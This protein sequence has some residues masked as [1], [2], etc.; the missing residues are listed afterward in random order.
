MDIPLALI[1]D[2]AAPD[3][4]GKLNIIGAFNRIAPAVFPYTHPMMYLVIK[5]QP[6]RGEYDE[7]RTA[8]AELVDE[9]GHPLFRIEARFQVPR[10]PDHS[11]T[12]LNIILNMVG[13][14]FERAGT[15]EFRVF[16]DKEQKRTVP[17]YLT[18]RQQD[19][20]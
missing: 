15:Y 12:D 19:A 16:I 4:A 8:R 3:S 14:T 20:P 7:E 1:A 18:L 9:D 2:Y 6:D 11:E 5:I 10:P 13:V 17:L